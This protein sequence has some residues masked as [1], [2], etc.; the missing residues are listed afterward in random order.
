MKYLLYTGICGFGN[1]L[2]GFKEACIIAK[3][4]NRKVVAPIFIP[5]GTIRKHCNPYYEF[6]DIFDYDYFSN[7]IDIVTID[8]INNIDIKNVY[9]VRC[10]N[11]KTL[12]DNYYSLSNK[13]YKIS[14][15]VNIKNINLGYIK[16]IS[17]IKDKLDFDDEVLVLSGLFN[18]VILSDC[19][20]NGCL[21]NNCSFNNV[22]YEDYIFF[23]KN[24]IFNKN[25][26]DHSTNILDKLYSNKEK[27]CV[28][29]LRTTDLPKNKTFNE[30]YGYNEK[31]IYSSIQ[32]YLFNNNI[33]TKFIV[34]APPDA[35]NIK[36]MN[37]F[38]N[39]NNVNF[40]IAN[41]IEDLF[42]RSL[43]EL[44]IGL[45]CD[46]LIFSNT[47]TPEIKKKHTRSSFCMHIKDI[48][49]DKENINV[50]D[51]LD[52]LFIYR[53]TSRGLFSEINIL[54]LAID[55]CKK[56]NY[57]LKVEIDTREGLN[58]KL[59]FQYGFDKYFDISTI[60]TYDINKNYKNIIVS[61]GFGKSS[62][63]I[64]RLNFLSLRRHHT[65]YNEMKLITNHIKLSKYIGEKI[66]IKI[67]SFNLPSEYVFFHIRRGDKL[68][69]ESKLYKF[70]DYLKFHLQN[71]KVNHIKDIFIAS[72]DFNV[73]NESLLYIKDNNMDF[74]IFHN[75]SPN[76]KGHNTHYNNVKKLY[77]DEDYFVNLMSDIEVSKFAQ[78]IYCTFTSNLGRF[79]ALYNENITSL[80]IKTWYSG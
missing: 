49:I 9:N 66:N 6:K 11:D 38:N 62:E 71:E 35:Y 12:V 73:I 72:D 3:Y 18:N 5:H 55:Y 7:N 76:I 17:C 31:L 1:Q 44:Q 24:L 16:D 41:K 69:H 34:I 61:G 10:D 36:D 54:L 80:D 74:K 50:T 70:S 75:C 57:Y 53:I 33:N 58:G 78:H 26:Q 40:N 52:K 47:N 23:S 32:T 77:F 21:N 14:D 20:K 51:I 60:E 46:T 64:T 27:F 19:L 67:S 59:Y 42:I 4:T 25:I 63:D 22:F 15:N 79:T 45:V 43:V 28:F 65:T 56:N 48:R 13:Y 68:K 37:I 39:N 2:L 29:H 30:S 8:D